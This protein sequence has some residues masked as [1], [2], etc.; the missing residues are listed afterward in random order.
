MS[1][2]NWHRSVRSLGF[3]A[4][5]GASALFLGASPG[6][7][8]PPKTAHSAGDYHKGK[9]ELPLIRGVAVPFELTVLATP[10]NC[11]RQIAMKLSW[12]EEE[13]W[14]KVELHGKGVLERYPTFHRTPGVNFVPNAF[15]PESQNIDNGRY[16]LWIIS[17]A[18]EIKFYYSGTTLDL[19]GSEYDFPV[20]PPGSLDV[21][22]P[23]VKVFPLPFMQPE[24]NGDLDFEFTWAYDRT[25]RGDRPEFA[26]HMV[27]FPPPNLCGANPFRFDLS[28]VR[29][30]ISKPL[31]VAKARPFSDFLRNGFLFDI[32][33][34]PAQYFTE[35]PLTTQ[36]ATY[37]N[38]TLFGGAVPK[39]YIWDI[40]ASFMNVAPPIKPWESAGKC[41]D[42]YRP[43]HTQNLNFCSP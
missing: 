1:R 43:L 5:L 3:A 13:N 41:E 9:L 42:W 18:E 4:T 15:W 16:Q 40:D 20:Q 38:S 19:L 12:D 7:A 33:V 14:V 17:P 27:S 29:G 30:Y 35:P 8:D 2:S 22:L 11:E 10:H 34:E 36:I 37:G 31:P 39:G 23:T 28:T 24:A 6:H 26:H 21:S 25:L 32:T